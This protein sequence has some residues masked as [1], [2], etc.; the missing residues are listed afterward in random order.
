MSKQD[1]SEQEM[2]N[3]KYDEL[4]KEVAKGTEMSLLRVHDLT[5][6]IVDIK[7]PILEREKKERNKSMKAT[8]K[9]MK[10]LLDQLR[11][12]ANAREKVT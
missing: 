4:T 6:E 5:H 7:L 10:R 1:M 11:V 12:A 2:L 8:H 3:Q 9:K